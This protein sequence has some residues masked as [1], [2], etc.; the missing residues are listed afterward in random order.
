M[1]HT[2]CDTSLIRIAYPGLLDVLRFS[3]AYGGIWEGFSGSPNARYK[4]YP[5]AIAIH[6]RQFEPLLLPLC[7]AEDP[8]APAYA[9]N[10]KAL[11][12]HT[13]RVLRFYLLL[14]NFEIQHVKVLT[15][16]SVR[17]SGV[18]IG[19]HDGGPS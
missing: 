16:L 13:L 8:L 19:R 3:R 14:G 1:L 2:I 10:H 4:R 15:V 17:V 18:M 12:I 7:L 11:L 6:K 9:S 5:F